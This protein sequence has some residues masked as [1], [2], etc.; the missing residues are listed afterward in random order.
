[1]AGNGIE[2]V[3]FIGL[4][5]MGRRMAATLRRAGFELTVWNR[6]RSVAEAFATQHG[7]LVADTPAQLGAR[8]D[9]VVTMVTDGDAVAAVLTGPDGVA[10]GAPLGLLCVDCS[11]IGPTA[12]RRIAG[13]L[14]QQEIAFVDAPVSGSLPG[15][16][17]GTLTIMVGGRDEDVQRARPL[18]DA[19]GELIV[20]VGDL[21]QGQMVKVISNAMAV[22]NVV[23]VGES[24]LLAKR[25]G[26][27]LDAFQ[28]VVPGTSGASRMLD[29]KAT[30]M[31]THDYTPMFTLELMLKDVRLCLEEAQ[32]NGIPYGSAALGRQWLAAGKGRGL[33][34]LDYAAVIEPLE[35][36]AGERL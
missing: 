6:T 26:V 31:R 11:T 21:G 15:A 10:A 9:A 14:A 24:L 8:V 2:R 34:E 25:A 18:L 7:A 17:A 3:G 27:D 20:H 19:M 12:A 1:M 28:R 4:G 29:Q 36:A 16:E 22:A 35:G 32:A 13:V 23:A 33:G 5:A 30:P